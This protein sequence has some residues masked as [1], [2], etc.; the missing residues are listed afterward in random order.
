MSVS[1]ICKD[2]FA[3]IITYALN[4]IIEKQALPEG[5]WTTYAGL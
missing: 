3:K 1:K 4:Y 2:D 5:T